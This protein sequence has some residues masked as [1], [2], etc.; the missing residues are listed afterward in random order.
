M[1]VMYIH[2]FTVIDTRDG[3]VDHSSSMAMLL[4]ELNMGG[5]SSLN[6]TENS[7]SVAVGIMRQ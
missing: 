5:A 7:R 6:M 2:H 4:N 3:T 1:H